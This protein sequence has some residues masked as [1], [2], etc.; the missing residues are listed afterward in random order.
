MG[1]I[2]EGDKEVQISNYKINKSWEW[3]VQ[4]REY[5][6]QHRQCGMMTGGNSTYCDKH[7]IMHINVIN[8]ESLYF[9]PETNVS[10]IFQLKKY[11]L[12]FFVFFE[13]V[14]VFLT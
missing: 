5:S 3:N 6:Q 10:T 7:F 9:I 2:S 11:I 8:V 4:Q 12:L 13:F 1:K 14:E